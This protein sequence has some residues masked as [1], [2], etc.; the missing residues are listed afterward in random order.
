[1]RKCTSILGFG[2][3]MESIFAEIKIFIANNQPVIFPKTILAV[4]EGLSET[5]LTMFGSS[6]RDYHNVAHCSMRMR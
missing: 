6:I 5:G 1:M 4:N 2:K 3:E